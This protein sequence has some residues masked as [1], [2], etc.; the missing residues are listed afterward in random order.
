LIVSLQTDLNL[1]RSIQKKTKFKPLWPKVLTPHQIQEIKDKEEVERK[2]Q[3]LADA[4]AA[5][6]AALLVAQQSKGKPAPAQAKPAAK[7]D[8]R[9]ASSL[10]SARPSTTAEARR[11]IDAVLG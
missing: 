5:Q 7:Q 4:T 10:S 2:A 11:K 8:S 3:E 9:P 6:E 1:Y